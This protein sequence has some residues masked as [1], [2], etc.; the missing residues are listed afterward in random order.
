MNRRDALRSLAGTGAALTLEACRHAPAP[1]GTL[2]DPDIER[3]VLALTGVVLKPGQVAGVREM[4]RTMRFTGRVDP[5]VQPSLVFD[6]EV[7]VE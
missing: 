2:T 5:A 4:L 7:D 6:P 3:M 1:A